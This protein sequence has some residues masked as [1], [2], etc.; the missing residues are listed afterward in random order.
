MTYDSSYFG[1]MAGFECGVLTPNEAMKPNY[2]QCIVQSGGGS[3]IAWGM[4]I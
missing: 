2:Q 3:T 1:L 4:F